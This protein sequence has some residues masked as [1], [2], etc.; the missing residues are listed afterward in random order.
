M[1]TAD[2]TSHRWPDAVIALALAAFSFALYLPTL[3]HGLI[4]FDD[5]T[6]TTHP[7]LQRGLTPQSVRWAFTTTTDCTW[8]P[9]TWLSHMLDVE[10]FRNNWSGHHAT[11]IGLHA[12]NATLV[13]LLLSAMTQSRWRSA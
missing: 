13:F 3:S 7:M 11:S 5:P 10:L 9:L 4:D 2:R 8:F 6:Y 1:P 12:I